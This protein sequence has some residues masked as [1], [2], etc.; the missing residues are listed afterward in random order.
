MTR[1]DVLAEWIGQVGTA[2]ISGSVCFGRADAVDGIGDRAIAGAATE[3]ALQRMGQIRL[4]LLSERCD[5]HDHAGRAKAALE[6]LRLQESLLHWMQIAWL[7]QALDCRDGA[8]R[9]A[10]CRDQAGMHR[11]AIEPHSA[12]TTI[13]GVAALLDPERALV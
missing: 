5:G 6:S 8:P 4:L 9:R 12:C 13:A 1:N 2:G 10:K 11:L 7:T 3:I